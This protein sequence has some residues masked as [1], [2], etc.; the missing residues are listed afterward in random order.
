MASSSVDDRA[1]QAALL[2]S[3]SAF[4]GESLPVSLLVAEGPD[5][6]RAETCRRADAAERAQSFAR[7]T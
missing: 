4:S 6:Q 3:A 7:G 1:S 2:G 5:A